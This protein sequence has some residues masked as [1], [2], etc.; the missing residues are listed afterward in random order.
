[1]ISVLA[2]AGLRPGRRSGC[3]GGDVGNRTLTSTESE[4]GQRRNVRLLVLLVEDLRLAG[5]TAVDP[6]SAAGLPG[7]G[8]RPWRWRPTSPGRA[9]ARGGGKSDAT[10]AA[11]GRVVRPRRRCGRCAGGLP[12]TLRHSFCSL[13]LHEG[14]SVIYVAR[15]LGHD[16]KL[17]LATYGHVIEELEDAPHVPAEDA[18][19]P[20]A[21]PVCSRCVTEAEER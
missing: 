5:R 12:Y 14:R 9:A 1:M 20:R 21:Q 11:A 6:R 17:T 2:H 18:I 10:P 8:R 7:R 19:A 3:A 15:Q 16:A 4:T 13:L